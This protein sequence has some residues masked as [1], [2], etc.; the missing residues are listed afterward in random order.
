[1][2]TIACIFGAIALG[3]YL[4]VKIKPPRTDTEI[5]GEYEDE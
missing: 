3:I 5:W 4:W 2:L 1:V